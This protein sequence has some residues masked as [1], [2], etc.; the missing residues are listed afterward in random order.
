MVPK[1]QG[2]T[3][4]SSFKPWILSAAS[5][6]SPQVNRFRL[7]GQDF[8]EVNL[9][10]RVPGTRGMVHLTTLNFLNDDD[11]LLKLVV[12]EHDDEVSSFEFSDELDD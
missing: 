5:K 9:R 2:K 3:C 8:F 1:Q 12:S 11:Y 7:L 6:A 4:P 10:S